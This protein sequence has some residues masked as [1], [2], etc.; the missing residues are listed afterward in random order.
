[1]L[2]Q[3]IEIRVFG[4]RIGHGDLATRLS[5]DLNAGP[6][7]FVDFRVAIAEGESAGAIMERRWKIDPNSGPGIGAGGDAAI[8]DAPWAFIDAEKDHRRGCGRKSRGLTKSHPWA[9]AGAISSVRRAVEPGTIRRPIGGT[10]V[11]ASASKTATDGANCLVK[12]D[13]PGSSDGLAIQFGIRRTPG[14]GIGRTTEN[15]YVLADVG[16]NHSGVGVAKNGPTELLCATDTCLASA[17][18]MPHGRPAVGRWRVAI[19]R[20]WREEVGEV[21]GVHMERQG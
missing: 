14:S 13:A 10:D 21:H 7:P 6:F 2:G 17:P 3:P 4:R 8:V 5:F 1:M 11:T 16:C 9:I 20:V 15:T 18:I 19:V 12:R